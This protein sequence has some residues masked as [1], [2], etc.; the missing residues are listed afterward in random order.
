MLCLANGLFVL[1]LD[2][3]GYRYLL[4]FK[5][6]GGAVI[7]ILAKLSRIDID[8]IFVKIVGYQNFARTVIILNISVSG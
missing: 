4:I 2:A 5:G 1:S 3:D 7:G 8:Q 6:V